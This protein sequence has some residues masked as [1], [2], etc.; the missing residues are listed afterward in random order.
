MLGVMD[1]TQ[2]ATR[3]AT[4]IVHQ[5]RA[6]SRNTSAKRK[7]AEFAIERD[8]RRFAED[9][10]NGEYIRIGGLL[11][12]FS[13]NRN[14]NI[15]EVLHQNPATGENQIIAQYRQG[16]E[17][18]ERK[19]LIQIIEN[20]KSISRLQLQER[21]RHFCWMAWMLFLCFGGLT[22]AGGVAFLVIEESRWVQSCVFVILYGGF[23]LLM[24]L[25]NRVYEKWQRSN[26]KL[27]LDCA[28]MLRDW[29][30]SN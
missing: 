2:K 6:G 18:I 21:V 20:V 19:A 17:L 16:E 7:V 10:S 14:P 3:P 23:L 22:I 30:K 24:G 8:A 27:Q 4:W 13:E 28:R 5:I 29:L 11:G 12:L 26:Y 15:F 25:S 1:D 9:Q